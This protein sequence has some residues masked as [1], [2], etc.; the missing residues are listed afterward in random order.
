MFLKRKKIYSCIAIKEQ[1]IRNIEQALVTPEEQPYEIPKSWK[2]V[3]LSTICEYIRD[4]GD[5]PRNFSKTKTGI[6]TVP[7]IVTEYL[8]QFFD[9]AQ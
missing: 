4:G 2:W 7:L 9:V 1:K 3:K 6:Y 5:K 8:T